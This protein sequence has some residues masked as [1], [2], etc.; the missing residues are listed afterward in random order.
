MTIISSSEV[1]NPHPPKMS[2]AHDRGTTFA[3]RNV[4]QEKDRIQRLGHL[5]VIKK[6]L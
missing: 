5:Q 2:Y 3:Y 1:L 4:L 6:I